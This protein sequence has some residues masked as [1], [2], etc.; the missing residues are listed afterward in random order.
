MIDNA[1][2]NN[3]VLL[4][5]TLRVQA[6]I[7]YQDNNPTDVPIPETGSLGIGDAR[8]VISVPNPQTTTSPVL[9][10]PGARITDLNVTV[11]IN[12]D[13]ISDLRLT[14]IAPD[15]STAVV[16]SDRNAT[17]TQYNVV[18]DDQAVNS[19]VATNNPNGTFRPV[20][21]LADFNGMSPEG[22][23][24]LLV[25]DLEAGFTGTI[26]DFGL[27]FL[28]TPFT[29]VNATPFPVPDQAPVGQPF[30]S[31]LT[32]DPFADAD[33]VIGNT[34]VT[35]DIDHPNVSDLVITLIAPDGT[36]V[37]LVQN[38]GGDGDDFA[39]TVF[40]EY[41]QIPVTVGTAPFNG[42]YR[43]EG[44]LSVLNGTDPRKA[45]GCSRS[46][47]PG[48]AGRAP[49]TAGACRS[50]PSGRRKAISSCRSPRSGWPRRRSRS[51]RSATPT[52]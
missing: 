9:A 45:T 47:T 37:P 18:F 41:A 36:R 40:T 30:M 50:R 17:G 48:S 8:S 34:A 32:V 26:T 5:W 21:N 35:L 24:V 42:L 23:W 3:G 11:R 16:L 12:H 10:L 2:G 4:N 31:T 6:D 14:L 13:D 52:S 28:L 38:R 15:G 43:P 25:E 22:D 29:E 39:G 27:S 19:I 44:L 1:A 49:S 51:S 46:S 33:Y 20:G 7:P